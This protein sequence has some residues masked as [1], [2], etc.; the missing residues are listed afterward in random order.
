VPED[1]SYCAAQSVNGTPNAR[2]VQAVQAAYG[3]VDVKALGTLYAL[4]AQTG[5]GAYD[6]WAD[7][8]P[9]AE[10]ARELAGELIL[11]PDHPDR[12]RIRALIVAGGEQDRLEKAGR[13]FGP[14]VFRV[15]EQIK[16]GT[17]VAGAP[18][19]GCYWE[20]QD[21]KGEIIDNNFAANATRVE[22]TIR[23]SDYAFNSRGCGDWRPA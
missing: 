8:P 17:Y 12:K 20:R 1:Y 9:T 5:K 23:E 3:S 10:Q 13:A 19:D 15:G 16:P 7:G 14:G 18:G 21:R 11:C 22:V 4:C 6:T 2:E